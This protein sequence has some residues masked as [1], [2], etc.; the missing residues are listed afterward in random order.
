MNN[1]EFFNYV[2]DSVTKFM[3]DRYEISLNRVFKNNGLE[4]TGIVIMEEGR[5]AAPTIYLDDFYADY[6]SGKGLGEIIKEVV[7]IYEENRCRLEMDFS[8]FADY[9]KIKKHILFKILNREANR[10]L[11][12][13]VP[14][15]TYMDLAIVFYVLIDNDMIG[16]GT[17]LIHNNHMQMW[18][19]DVEELYEMAVQ[20]TPRLMPYRFS[21][22]ENVV[23]EIFGTQ[24]AVDFLDNDERST[25]DMYV[26]TNTKKLFGASCLLYDN[27]LKR[28]SDKLRSSLYIIPSS[29]HELI[30]IPQNVFPHG[31]EELKEMVQTINANE[32]EQVD[33]LSDN[34]YEY[35]R[36]VGG[37]LI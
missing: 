4:L 28:I 20:N 33:V 30:I 36:K 27:L 2:Q 13:D 12:E 25:Y 24:K 1:K 17:V 29:I 19:V 32:L 21:S 22:M 7:S 37:I 26:L 3:G 11:L 5:T 10:K 14:H 23:E 35:D 18:N 9:G 6:K 31:R 15:K 8:F 16:N 34:V